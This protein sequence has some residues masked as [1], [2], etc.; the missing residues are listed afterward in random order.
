MLQ[1]A[2]RPASLHIQLFLLKIKLLKTLWEKRASKT[3]DG[4]HSGS[5]YGPSQ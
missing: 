2:V 5:T 3:R 4:Y 1:P